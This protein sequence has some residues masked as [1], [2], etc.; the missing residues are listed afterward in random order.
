MYKQL[1]DVGHWRGLPAMQHEQSGRESTT[2]LQCLLQR[3]HDGIIT[4]AIS[5]HDEAEALARVDQNLPQAF[6]LMPQ[7]ISG[8]LQSPRTEVTVQFY[9]DWP[10]PGGDNL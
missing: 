2:L 1:L 9:L 3:L 5:G 6:I 4:T 10:A 7:L 8:I